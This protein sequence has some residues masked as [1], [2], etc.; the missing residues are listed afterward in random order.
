MQNRKKISDSELESLIIDDIIYNKFKSGKINA[1]KLAKEKGV[2][3]A[4]CRETLSRLAGKK[5]ISFNQNLGYSLNNNINLGKVC[6]T[7]EWYISICTHLSETIFLNMNYEWIGRLNYYLSI[8]E[9]LC[10]DFDFLNEEHFKSEELL[11]KKKDI[12]RNL[13]L[14]NRSFF[15]Y[16]FEN[17]RFAVKKMVYNLDYVMISPVTDFND[18]F[19][20]WYKEH[21]PY[22]KDLIN[23]LTIKDME[24]FNKSFR[25]SLE[26]RFSR[27]ELLDYK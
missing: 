13:M 25:S 15:L 5:I 22:L 21:I 26:H 24:L 9:S 2:G 10:R 3:I 6:D 19:F 7:H 1:A 12:L 16:L 14:N 4:L 23:C 27:Y 11:Y 20:S 17:S 8:W 18:I